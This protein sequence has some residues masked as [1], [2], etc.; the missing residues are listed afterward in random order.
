MRIFHSPVFNGPAKV[1]NA[2]GTNRVWLSV[3][4]DD[5][6]AEII[7]SGQIGRDYYDQSGTSSKD[8][9]DALSQIP[10]GHKINLRIN[11]EGGSVQDGLEIYNAIKARAE[12]VT[13]YISGYAIS[14]ASVIPLAAARIVSP[15]SSIWMIH[16]P[17]CFSQGDA[18]AMRAT[19]EMLDK[20]GDT[21]AQ[22][23]S[24]KTGKSKKA[25][26]DA[27]KEETW[28]TGSQ[29]VEYGLADALEDDTED[30][31]NC[32][33]GFDQSRF[34]KLPA[35]ILN[36]LNPRAGSGA[37]QPKPKTE[38]SMDKAI[39]VALLKKHG[40]EASVSE[41]IE[42]LQAKLAQIPVAEEE[43]P[44]PAP[45]KKSSAAKKKAA[46]AEDDDGEEG[47]DD[48][49]VDLRAELA[50]IKR[51]RV[52]DKISKYVDSTVITK[53]E[54]DIYVNAALGD[55]AGTIKILDAKKTAQV[56]GEAAGAHFEY[57]QA[58]AEPFGIQGKLT[59]KARNVLNETKGDR[60]KAYAAMSSNWDM[61]FADARR[62]DK[63]K[64]ENTFSATLTTNFLILGATSQLSPKFAGVK[65]FTRDTTVDPYKPLATGVMKFN[66]TAQDGSTTQTNATNF[67]SGDSD[68]QPVSITVNQYTESFHLRN[69]DLNSG[70]RMEDLVT[71]K[72]AS[73]GTKISKVIGANITAANFATL[74]PI[75]SAPG[76]FGFSDMAIAWGALKKANRKNIM[77]DGEYLARIINNPAFL[78]AV[79]VVPGAGWKNVIGWDYVALH[80]DW[81]AAGANVRGFAA[82]PQA[83]GM[84]AGLPLMDAPGIPGGILSMATGVI[85]GI[86]LAIAAFTWFNTSTRTY[87][88]S[89]DLTLGA[90]ALDKSA[91]L[92][93]ASGVPS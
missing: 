55:E 72:L 27:M 12:D 79:P 77:L 29:A 16:D 3:T 69:V 86:D 49:V 37:G 78:Q 9:R 58:A 19:A 34:N 7:I 54:L 66:D 80:T 10:K 1:W 76:A 23:Y 13:C 28:F 88:G 92:V 84:I 47:D 6:F 93:I 53:D 43:A 50:Q 20:H 60:A 21:L 14:I 46:V 91:G 40:I 15:I 31:R 35:A 18:A 22:I 63:V 81:S 11:S 90:N 74:A 41:T 61:L 36:V 45:K 82:D 25:M 48:G 5:A 4:Q 30:T 64:N 62:Q 68:L 71:N 89:F 32:L 57:G 56:G 73:L 87:W 2:P 51:D 26:R 39:I 83:L 85:P 33:R 8:F 24:A 59:E 42:Q 65:M 67:E 44:A 75:V 70:I 52:A 17:W 38:D